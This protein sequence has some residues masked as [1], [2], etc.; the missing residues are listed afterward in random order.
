M[1]TIQLRYFASVRERLH[2]SEESLLVANKTIT[3]SGIILQLRSRGPLWDEVLDPM[4]NRVM[5]AVNEVLASSETQ[6]HDGDE[7]AL[8]PPVTGG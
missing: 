5:I 1:L 6:L 3:V 4:R 2:K 8:F 7:L